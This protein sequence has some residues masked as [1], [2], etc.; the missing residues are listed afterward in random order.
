MILSDD[1]SRELALRFGA[2]AVPLDSVRADR[3]PPC[4]GLQGN[5]RK[6]MCLLHDWLEAVD[7]EKDVR[8]NFAPPQREIKTLAEV[9]AYLAWHKAI[10]RATASEQGE[11][12]SYEQVREEV[13]RLIEAKACGMADAMVREQGEI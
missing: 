11:E 6:C 7:A 4:T 5:P 2:A 13:K 9:R 3:L 12:R 10:E 1:R 8:G